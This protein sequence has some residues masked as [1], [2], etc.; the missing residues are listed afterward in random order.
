MFIKPLLVCFAAAAILSAQSSSPDPATRAH[1]DSAYGK[2]P[3]QFEANQGQQPAQVKFLS[4]AK[5]STVFLTPEGIML[6]LR[7]VKAQARIDKPGPRSP[8]Y[9][10]EAA[11]DLRLKLEGGNPA[12]QLTGAEPLPGVLNYFIGKDP[13]QWRA[14]V[15]TYA[16][17]RY[18][19]I[20]PGIDLVFYGNQTQLE[21]DF[22]L[23]P[24]AQPGAIR[25][26]VEGADRTSVD[27]ATGDLVLAAAGQE[28]RFHKP[29]VYQPEAAG[30]PRREVNGRFHVQK[31]EVT[32]ELAA[33]DHARPLVVDPVL[34]YST[35][36]GGSALDWAQAVTVD[37]QGNAYIGGLTC[38]SN[39]PT[40]PASYSPAEPAPVESCEYGLYYNGAH[41]FVTKLNAA[42]SALVY[43]TYLGG[44]YTDIVA[45]I[46]VDSSGNAYVGGQTWSFNFPVTAGAFQP[47]CAPVVEAYP[48]CTSTT[49]I[50]TC[51][52][53]SESS[54]TTSGFVTKLNAT[55]SALV[56][57][58]FIGGSGNSWVAA[59]GVNSSNEAYVAGNDG[60][61]PAWGTLCS[62]P[63]PQTNFPWPTT[64]NGYEGWPTDGLPD[65]D[66]VHPAFSVLSADGSSLLYSTLYGPDPKQAQAGAN[67]TIVS[68]MAI[69]S[70]G[71]AYIS[72]YTNYADFPTTAG[73]YQTACPACTDNGTEPQNDGFVVAFD[74]SQIGG[75]SLAYSTFLGGS[76]AG[77]TGGFCT[78][79]GGDRANGIAVDSKSNAYVTGS[80]CSTNFPT[81]HRA[82][83]ATDPTPGTCTNGT[84]NAF[85]SKLNSTGTALDYSTYLGG[86]TCD[87]NTFAYGVSV[88]SSDDAFVTG[89]TND[90]TFPTMNPIFPSDAYFPAIFVTE[91]NPKASAL[92]FST[93]LGGG[94]DNDAGWRIHADN[95]GNIYVAGL[96]I[97]GT[98]LPITPGAFQTT[99]G[100]AGDAFAMRIALTQAD[101]AVTNSA[102]ST[103]L[104]GTN[105]TYTIVVTNNG[106]D[107]AD[108]IT[109]TDSIPKGTTF[110]SATTSAGSCKTP[111]A[112][113]DSGKV[114]CMVTSLADGAGF[115]LKMI[116]D[117]KEKS[118]T[119]T[120]TTTVSSL[121]FDADTGNNTAIATTTVN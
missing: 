118:G 32:F 6:S 29:V 83:Q 4:R 97:G 69:D 49:T 64:A 27:N 61:Y 81:T 21:Y 108:V 90:N 105:L 84:P 86:S 20:Y 111:A 22:V 46:A 16:K 101:L 80:V 103:V 120:D 56:Y 107:A 58:T 15:A 33:Y 71:K 40:T 10:V 47:T 106:P 7:K 115:S 91:L 65:S 66:E 28:I 109:L 75:A 41:G 95:Y 100:G 57:S 1:I 34:A 55:G 59:L 8:E 116:V 85:L 54:S 2:L 14:N 74:P 121:I 48:S 23:A 112:G 102:P 98:N 60:G 25:M 42:G 92:L 45:A 93:L 38:S 99:Y 82:F 88:D 117:V 67:N 50:S 11:A 12:V 36:L 5:D 30:T 119:L 77:Y 17:V 31:D 73:A 18:E 110:V 13:D 35:F 9:I 113:A 79:A 43:S 24:G 19:R 89:T 76:G 70:A 114:T 62:P 52:G 104:T 26:S 87:D 51:Q 3:L 72:G 53:A 39:F 44:S 78:S 68:S 37:K 94:N 63:G 96:T